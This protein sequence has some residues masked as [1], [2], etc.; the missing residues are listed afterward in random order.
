MNDLERRQRRLD[1][2]RRLI[3]L[4]LAIAFAAPIV[5][6]FLFVAAPPHSHPMFERE[7]LLIQSLV[8]W[9]GVAMFIV[10]LVWM[11]RIY[12]ADPEAG[13]SAW[14]YRDY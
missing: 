4:E 13:E 11:I 6:G 2:A 14:R 3:R 5:L 9:A 10:G 7:P 1:R 12:R 8:V